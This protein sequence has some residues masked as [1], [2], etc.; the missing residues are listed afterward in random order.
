MSHAQTKLGPNPADLIGNLPAVGSV[1]PAFVL[2]AN[3]MS[4]KTLK[5]FEGKTVVLN[6]FPSI[7]TGVCATS[8]R[9][10]NQYSSSL[11]NTVVICVAK[12]LPFA[13]KRFCGA[14]GIDRIVTLSDFRSR[15]FGKDYGVELT[16]SSF[17]GLFARAI[18]V[19]DPA[20]KVKYTELVPTIGQEP[21][22]EAA[23]KAI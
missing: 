22:Y 7:D 6:I 23:L 9:K 1:A 16:S 5:D 20:G 14:E 18:V 19:I 21:D 17:A 11:Q 8:T 3:D 13:F 12:D 15:G 4:D 2:S 10:F